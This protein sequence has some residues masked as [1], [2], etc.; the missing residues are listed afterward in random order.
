MPELM[1][2]ICTISRSEDDLF[3]PNLVTKLKKTV[4]NMTLY[5]GGHSAV[6]RSYKKK[7]PRYD[8]KTTY[9]ST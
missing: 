5:A 2:M 4:G 8:K 1:K 3:V 9:L 7:F 6:R